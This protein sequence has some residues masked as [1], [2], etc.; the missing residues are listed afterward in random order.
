VDV[1]AGAGP[2]CLDN[3][4]HCQ[5][6]KRNTKIDPKSPEKLTASDANRR[7]LE[8]A[9]LAVRLGFTAFGI[10]AAKRPIPSK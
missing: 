8:V 4:S 9:D 10:H 3:H 2:Y 5:Q 1:R 7:L 6:A